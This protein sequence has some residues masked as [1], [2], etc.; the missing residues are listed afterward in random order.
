MKNMPKPAKI[1]LTLCAGLLVI[2]MMGVLAVGVAYLYYSPQL[3][4]PD[5]LGQPQFS[6]PLRIFTADGKLLAQYGAK[7]RFP[8][9]YEQIPRQVVNAFVAAEDKRFFQHHG[10]D[11][12]GLVRAGVHLLLTGKKTQGG[13]TITMQLA[14]DLYLSRRRIYTRKFK[15]I[16]IALR[17]ESKYSKQQ[18]LQLYLNKI[19]LGSHAYGVGAAARV[20]YNKPLAKLD[21]AQV[22]TIAGLPKAPSRYNPLVNP[23]RAKVRRDYVLGQM[24]QDG[25]IDKTQYTHAKAEPVVADSSPVRDKSFEANYVAEM[26]R[27]WLYKQHGAKTY[28]HGY[29][30][31]TTINSKRQRAADRALRRD[32]LDYDRRHAWHGPEAHL[33]DGT[34]KD[35]QALNAALADRKDAGGLVPAAVLSVKGQT[36]TLHTESHGKV[37]LQASDMPWL[38]KGESAS[39]LLSRGDVVRLAYT[40]KDKAKWEL[41]EIP[42]VQGA[43]VALNPGN[44]AIEALVG[45][46]DYHQSQFNRAT[47]ARR[48]P[49]SA[50]KPFIYSAALA[51]G[52]TPATIIN[53]A[54]VVFESRAEGKKWRPHNYGDAVHGPTRLRVGLVDSLNLVTIRLL[55]LVG[56]NTARDYAARF[57]LPESRMPKDLTLALGSGTFSP[58]Q[59]ARGYAVFAN[60]GYLVKPHFINKIVDRDGDVL[61]RA[62]PAQACTRAVRKKT[63]CSGDDFKP[64]KRVISP[65]NAYL[66]T[67]LM[68]G[69]IRH[70]TGRRALRLHR[71]DLAGKTGTSNKQVNAWFA[72]FNSDLTTVCWVGFDQPKTLGRGETGAHA[73]LPM[74]IDFMGSALKGKPERTM[75]RPSG[76]VTVRIDKD[77]GKLASPG[78]EHTMFETFRKANVPERASASQGE[79]A[80]ESSHGGHDIQQLF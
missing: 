57:G 12:H 44:G 22:A 40:G 23:Q 15:E 50:F 21:L 35:R 37:T 60:G 7:R 2:F 29:D 6:E 25:F 14:R 48:Q 5:D 10:V 65:Q 55:D 3:P 58:L 54:P 45:G 9:T 26:V 76:L 20:Y 61:F 33:D 31:Y 80:G 59:I 46:F 78:S 11:F 49:G 18:I 69:V 66:M 42:T 43:L 17:M 52:F 56:I 68:H 19:Y 34:L 38:H 53:D 16:L 62:D 64:A 74:W 41:A 70:G 73:A 30:V 24:F 13:S 36:A 72:G 32:L 77:T 8:L 1:V 63:G 47:Q 28:T 67:S 27:R 4:A 51:N 79:G 71:S 39:K 75:P